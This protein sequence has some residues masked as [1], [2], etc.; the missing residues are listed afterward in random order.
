MAR[1]TERNPALSELNLRGTIV[2]TDG[3]DT[4]FASD[5]GIIWINTYEGNCEYTLPAVADAKGKMF[6]FAQADDENFKITSPAADIVVF[7]QSGITQQTSVQY[8]TTAEGAICAVIS[9]GTRYLFLN[10]CGTEPNTL[11]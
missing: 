6:L 4:L 7:G 5:S 1:T 11:A 2:S 8:D 3:S 10:F 9:D